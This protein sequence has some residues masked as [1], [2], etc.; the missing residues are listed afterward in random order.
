MNVLYDYV[1][2]KKV[3]I[4][5]MQI[6]VWN[7]I[8]PETEDGKKVIC[9]TCSY[10]VQDAEES[11]NKAGQKVL[12]CPQCKKQIRGNIHYKIINK[13]FL[14]SLIN[15]MIGLIENMSL[16]KGTCFSLILKGLNL[17]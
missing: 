9:S 1:S 16:L 10:L 12:L 13:Q 14:K 4:I 5:R 7:E 6:G 2:K 3:P 15:K 8:Y 17:I 11:T